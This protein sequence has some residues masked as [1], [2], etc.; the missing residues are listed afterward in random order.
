MVCLGWPAII[1][2]WFFP[3]YRG[4]HDYAAGTLVI[5]YAGVKRI[6]AY[7]TVQIKL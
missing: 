3:G 6:D 4:P 5:N 2:G 7:E 1:L